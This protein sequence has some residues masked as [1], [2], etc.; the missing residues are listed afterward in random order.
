MSVALEPDAS[1]DHI[2]RQLFGYMRLLAMHP[3]AGGEYLAHVAKE[4]N[5]LLADSAVNIPGLR[6]V[7]DLSANLESLAR[8]ISTG[9]EGYLPVVIPWD[10]YAIAKGYPIPNE[11]GDHRMNRR[12]MGLNFSF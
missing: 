6:K 11:I 1:R 2:R 9:Y 8:S 10:L 12:T 7:V 3:Y 4:I 5:A